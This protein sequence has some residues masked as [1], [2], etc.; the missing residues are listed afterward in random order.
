LGKAVAY[1][2]RF[3]EKIGIGFSAD[4]LFWIEIPE[5]W[6]HIAVVRKQ[7]NLLVYM[8][9]DLMNEIIAPEII[10]NLLIM[11]DTDASI[12]Y[13]EASIYDFIILDTSLNQSDIAYMMAYMNNN[14]PILYML[15]GVDFKTYG[16]YVSGS[17]GV[18]NRPKLKKMSS[19]SWDNYH[20]ESVDLEHKFYEPREI[21]LDC[22]IIAEN[23]NDFINKLS[24]FEQQFDKK[25]T[26]RLHIESVLKRPLIY[27]V[28]C[29][30]EISVTKKWSNYTQTGTFKIKLTE[31][32]PVKKVLRHTANESNENRC[33]ISITTEKLV[34]IYWGDGTVD[35]DVYGQNVSITH[36]YSTD[37]VYYPVITGCIDEIS[38]FTTNAIIVWEKI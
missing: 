28:Y 26:N 17:E 30:D 25:G 4:S 32:E 29:K 23:R 20:G 12:V 8:N 7:D 38:E 1:R 33:E 24:A 10:S 2:Y 15:D 13:A 16:V 31:P 22:F 5:E 36:S 35:Y 27:E 9:G 21:I 14:T 18:I 6:V 37:A 34:N 11:Q 19:F 3:R